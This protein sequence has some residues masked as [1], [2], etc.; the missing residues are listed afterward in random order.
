MVEEPP[1]SFGGAPP[2]GDTEMVVVLLREPERERLGV[3][4]GERVEVGGGVLL[5]M[6][7]AQRD[8]ELHA[9]TE[10][11][12]VTLAEARGECSDTVRVASG[13]RDSEAVA[14]GKKEHESEHA[15]GRDARGEAL[16]QG[17]TSAEAMPPEAAHLCSSAWK[18]ITGKAVLP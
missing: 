8:T 7:E 4:E 18:W 5:R 3:Y 11:V 16:A 17:P 1:P 6:E 9:D 15:S 13:L 2:E 14:E 10:T 12:P